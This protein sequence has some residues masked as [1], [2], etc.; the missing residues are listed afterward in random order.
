[1]FDIDKWQEIFHT[2]R[3]NKLRTGLTAFGVFWGIFMLIFLLGSGTGLENGVRRDFEDEAINSIYMWTGTT[4][5]PYDGLPPGRPIHF[6]QADIDAIRAEVKGL[7]V[8]APRKNV[9]DQFPVTREEKTGAFT[10]MG[11]TQDY[12]RVYMQ[13]YILGRNLNEFDIMERRKVCTIGKRVQEVLFVENADPIGQYITIKGSVF[14]VVGVFTDNSNNGRN[15]ERIYIP[16]SA[17]QQV[18]ENKDRISM[19]A[20][21]TDGTIPAKTL[22]DRIVRLIARRHRFDPEDKQAMGI[23]NTEENY[24]QFQSV[25]GAINGLIWVVGLGTLAAGIIGVSNI[26]IIIVKERTREIGIRK[27][28]GATPLSVVSLIVQESILITA[29]SGYFG[30]VAGVGIIELMAFG[31]EQM[32]GG[33][34]FFRKP[35]IDFNVALIATIILVV[36]GALSGLL[37]AMKAARIKPV[38]AFR[39]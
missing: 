6:T 10:I 27:A 21:T 35:E 17:Y 24:K 5:L 1:M 19:I 34:D 8:L 13:E 29:V 20:V 12:N 36:A 9:W 18:F 32:G 15:Q 7:G 28:L 3:K 30:L 11:T 37:P 33:L 16:I 14:R 26:M 38:E 2:I 39:E 22:E 23:D 31:L 25:F 4:S